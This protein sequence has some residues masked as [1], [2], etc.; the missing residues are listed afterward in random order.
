MHHVHA[1]VVNATRLLYKCTKS[2]F[3][4]SVHVYYIVHVH[5]NNN[6]YLKYMT[7][8]IIYRSSTAIIYVQLQLSPF[9]FIIKF[10]V[11]Y[12]LSL[13]LMHAY[14]NMQ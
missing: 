9:R 14:V 11:L 6:M 12:V 2:C 13:L 4:Q 1:C 5:I 3:I 7:L 8:Y 10:I